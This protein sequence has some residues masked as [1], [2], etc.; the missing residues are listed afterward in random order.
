MQHTQTFTPVYTQNTKISKKLYKASFVK[1][2]VL[3]HDIKTEVVPIISLRHF[4]RNTQNFVLLPA[5]IPSNATCRL[6]LGS[7]HALLHVPGACFG[8]SLD[9]GDS[10]HGLK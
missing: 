4:V 5:E 8:V 7:L 9:Q 10:L 6:G 1:D 2:S 3:D